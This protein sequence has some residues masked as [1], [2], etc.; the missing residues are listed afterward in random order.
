[1][2]CPPHL[3]KVGSAGLQGRVVRQGHTGPR[4]QSWSSEQA[5]PA[6]GVGRKGTGRGGGC[7]APLPA[8]GSLRL[9]VSSWLFSWRVSGLCSSGPCRE[10]REVRGWRHSGS[11]PGCVVSG[12]WLATHTSV[13]PG[14]QGTQ[15]RSDRPGPTKELCALWWPTQGSHPVLPGQVKP[16]RLAHARWPPAGSQQPQGQGGVSNQLF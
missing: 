8:L 10:A 1:M 13:T 5:G 12:L 4:H 11:S 7:A 6:S 2:S 16:W 9:C 3:A 14:D 15:E